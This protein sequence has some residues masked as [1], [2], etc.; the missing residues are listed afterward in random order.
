MEGFRGNTWFEFIGRS[1]SCARVWPDMCGVRLG[2]GS[3]FSDRFHYLI[4]QRFLR[5]VTPGWFSS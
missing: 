1:G 5:V 4:G 2:R 3:G